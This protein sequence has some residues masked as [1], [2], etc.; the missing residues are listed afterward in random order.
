[1][2]LHDPR[3]R[4]H[5]ATRARDLHQLFSGPRGRFEETRRIIRIAHEFAIGGRR[6]RRLG[7]CVTVFG[8]ARLGEDS[9]WYALT[10]SM[11]RRLAEAGFAV[12]TGGGPGLMEAANRGAR[13]G[14]GRSIGCN[15]ALPEEQFPNPYLDRWLDFRYF[16]VRK[17]MLV[18]YSSGFVVMP[19]GFGTMDELFEVGTLIQTAKIGR[20]PVVLMGREFYEPIVARFREAFLETGTADAKDFAYAVLTDDPEEAIAHLA[21]GAVPQASSAAGP[22]A[23]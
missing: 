21:A 13:E 23:D 1:M 14:G 4:R 10:R 3:T 8:S 20:F 12:M 9:S 2:T 19:G 18:K 22:P 11:G 16:F 5:H 15:I 7:P 6:L 17:V